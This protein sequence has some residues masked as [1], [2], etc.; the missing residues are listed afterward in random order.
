MVPSKIFWI[1]QAQDDLR[2][3]RAHIARDAPATAA[4]YVSKL[5]LSVSRL[6]HFPF[7]GAI[8]AEGGKEDLRDLFQGNYRII[9]SD[10]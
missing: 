8:V 1:R 10:I 7:S 5:R 4:A 6:R 9:V 3:I 2:A